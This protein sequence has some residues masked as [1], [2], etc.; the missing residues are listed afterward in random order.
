MTLLIPISFTNISTVHIIKPILIIT[1]ILQYFVYANTNNGF[2]IE[3][4]LMSV[5]A[6]N[7]T[8]K[9]MNIHSCSHHH[10]HVM[11]CSRM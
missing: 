11:K 6:L 3:P 7:A 8:T 2:T 10:H 4:I 1:L 9:L 5:S